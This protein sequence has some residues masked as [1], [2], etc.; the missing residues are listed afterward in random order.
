VLH[1][2]G[3]LATIQTLALALLMTPTLTLALNLAQSN[4]SHNPLPIYPPPYVG[5]FPSSHVDVIGR[6]EFRPR[7]TYSLS[8]NVPVPVAASIHVCSINKGG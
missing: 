4:S 1:L 5:W 2:N 6:P 3:S 7:S 8:K